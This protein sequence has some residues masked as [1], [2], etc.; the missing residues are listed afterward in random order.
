[1]DSAPCLPYSPREEREEDCG[2]QFSFIW[3]N[4]KEVLGITS[5]PLSL[6]KPC[7]MSTIS[8]KG[9][10]KVWSLVA[11][12]CAWIKLY[13]Y[14]RRAEWTWGKWAAYHKYLFLKALCDAEKMSWIKHKL[15]VGDPES[16]FALNNSSIIS[17]GSHFQCISFL[18][19][20]H[21]SIWHQFSC[22]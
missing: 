20:T 21:I 12:P 8:C 3:G 16:N 2:M 6:V 10:W 19:Q 5:T 18:S 1:M 15:S 17:M 7:H 14:R 13:Y 4:N 9:G 22:A 11:W